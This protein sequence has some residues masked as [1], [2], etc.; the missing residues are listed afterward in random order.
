M[1][2][3]GFQSKETDWWIFS[4]LPIIIII[5]VIILFNSAAADFRS[6]VFIIGQQLLFFC[7]VLSSTDL[8]IKAKSGLNEKFSIGPTLLI[9][10]FSFL[11]LVFAY[12]IED[13]IKNSRESL[14]LYSLFFVL[15]IFF[16]I[17]SYNNNPLSD[18]VGSGPGP[19]EFRDSREKSYKKAQKSF[20]KSSESK[21]SDINLGD[22]N[23]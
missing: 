9:L 23:E 4:L 10:I 1:G 18:P 2:F 21:F 7:V 8:G 15:S 14:L 17:L 12:K 19:K 22:D 3:L 5:P 11:I 6:V 20:K 16:S 13:I